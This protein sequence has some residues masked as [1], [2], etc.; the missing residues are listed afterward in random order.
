[1]QQDGRDICFGGC[2]STVAGAGRTG[3]GV[4]AD[5]G[6]VD[7]FCCLDDM[8]GV[9][10]DAGVAEKTTVQ[11]GWNGF[12]QL[13]PLLATRDV[14]L[15]VGGRLYSSCVQGGVLHG[16][17]TWPMGKEGGVALQHAG[18]RVVGWVCG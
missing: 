4:G 13:M 17:W 7:G 10:G 6:L 8:L 11:V 5:L 18:V 1:M 9:D 16:S 15:M 14:S 12:R 3:V 2:A